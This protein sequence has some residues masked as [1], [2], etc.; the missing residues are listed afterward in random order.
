MR[1]FNAFDRLIN[2]VDASLRTLFV[3][4][5]TMRPSPAEQHKNAIDLTNA[6][7]INAGRLMRV[8][9][10]GEVAAQGLYRAQALTA[11]TP[12]IR[13]QMQHSSDEENEHLNWCETRIDALGTHK[14]YLNPLWY[15]GSFAIGSIAGKAG[16]RWSLGFVKETEDQ[17]VRHLNQHLTQLPAN[18]IEDL[19]VVKKMKAD[20][21]HHANV[22]ASSGASRLPLIVRK[23]FMPVTAK[24]MTTLSYRL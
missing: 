18:D 3:K 22:A 24:V 11:R 14:S 13:A 15:W 19:A 5:A 10:S 4:P 16:D 9:H 6:E 12:E 2:E 20:E 23:V 7:R 8:N 1:V 17:V 21:Q